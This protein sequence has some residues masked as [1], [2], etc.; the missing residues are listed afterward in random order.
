MLSDCLFLWIIL[1]G[2]FSQ[3]FDFSIKVYPCRPHMH[4]LTQSSQQK[5]LSLFCRWENRGLGKPKNLAKT[6]ELGELQLVFNPRVLVSSP[7][8]IAVSLMPINPICGGGCPDLL[9]SRSQISLRASRAAPVVKRCQ[10][11]LGRLLR[12]QE[13][14]ELTQHWLIGSAGN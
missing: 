3:R 10:P 7:Y 13:N 1:L 9:M 5:L 6:P 8:V 14:L 12:T 4:H 2:L 11:R